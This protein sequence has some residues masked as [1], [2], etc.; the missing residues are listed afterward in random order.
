[1]NMTSLSYR[2]RVA[3]GRTARRFTDL[4]RPRSTRRR[5][6][7]GEGFHHTV[8]EHASTLLKSVPPNMMELQRNKVR[9]LELACGRMDGLLLRPGDV[10]SFCSLVGPATRRRGYLDGMQLVRGELRPVAGG[11]LCQLANLVY[12]MGLHA[13]M[14]VLERHHHCVDLFPDDGRTVPFGMGVSIFYNYMD[15]RLRNSLPQPL[16]LRVAVEP[17]VLSGRLLSDAPP[18]CAVTVFQREHRYFRDGDGIVWRENR[19][20]R[21]TECG[22]G[23]VREEEIAHNLGRVLYDTSGLKVEEDASEGVRTFPES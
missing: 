20:Y 9:N 8:F 22:D 12:W 10:F 13:G 19:V 21:R 1:M 6:A 23:G 7:S 4:F 16:L 3:A 5:L 17:P 14:K 2:A 11:G 18:E 15:L